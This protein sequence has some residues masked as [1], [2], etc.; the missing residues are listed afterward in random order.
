MT[1]AVAG[2]PGRR[3]IGRSILA[4]FTGFI[5]VFVLSL[6]TDQLFHVLDVYP[7]W[8]TPMHE[9]ELNLLALSYRFVYTVLGGWIVAR[10][11]PHS[12]MK[13]VTIFAAIGLVLGLLG[14]AGSMT[15]ELGPI[16]YPVAVAVTGPI[17]AWLGGVLHQRRRSSGRRA[18]GS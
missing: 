12:P 8:G 9:P 4:V 6:G 11:A 1:S 10:L 2:T 15:A 7:P 3:S 5:I 16:W 14:V 17:G 13:H 18:A